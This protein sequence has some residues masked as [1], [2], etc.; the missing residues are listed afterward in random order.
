MLYDG[1]TLEHLGHKFRVTFPYDD[2]TTPPWERDDE[3]VELGDPVVAAIA[4]G[5]PAKRE[6]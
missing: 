2:D 3:P 4:A 5:L 1:D 6:G